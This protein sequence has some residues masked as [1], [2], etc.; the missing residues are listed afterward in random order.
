MLIRCIENFD[1]DC[2]FGFIRTDDI[3]S[4]RLCQASMFGRSWMIQ[5]M[6]VSNKMWVNIL[7]LDDMDDKQA[8]LE[9]IEYVDNV[10]EFDIYRKPIEKKDRNEKGE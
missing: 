2:E 5:G 1:G 7:R 4:W 6:S 10:Q 9:F 8:Q 3:T